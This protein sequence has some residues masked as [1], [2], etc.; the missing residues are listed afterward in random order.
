MISNRE[1][2]R[3]IAEERLK[4]YMEGRYLG[5]VITPPT[6][7]GKKVEDPWWGKVGVCAFSVGDNVKLKLLSVI[8]KDKSITTRVRR[9]ARDWVKSY[10]PNKPRKPWKTKKAKPAEGGEPAAPLEAM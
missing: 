3:E 10:D 2:G 7:A 6:V 5:K 9:A 4:L 1:R 8:A